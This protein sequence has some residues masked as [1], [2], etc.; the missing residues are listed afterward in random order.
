MRL[1]CLVWIM[2]TLAGCG[3]VAEERS[4]GDGCTTPGQCASGSC[5]DGV[6]CESACDAECEACSAAK[7]GGVSGTCGA[8]TASSDPDLECADRGAQSCGTN[9]TGCNGNADAPACNKYPAATL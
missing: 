7:T 4:N 3:K 1:C 6:C 9:G 5:V 2:V 8:V